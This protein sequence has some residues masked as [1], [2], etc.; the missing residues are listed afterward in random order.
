MGDKFLL[1]E[2]YTLHALP[3]LSGTECTEKLQKQKQI[4]KE[5][6]GQYVRTAPHSLQHSTVEG[7]ND[8][9]IP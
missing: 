8:S 6:R 1:G 5:S 3:T 7:K 9:V 2:L 4:H